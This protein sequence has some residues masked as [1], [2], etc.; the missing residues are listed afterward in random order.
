MFRFGAEA[1]AEKKRP[2]SYS[3]LSLWPINKQNAPK[4]RGREEGPRG[5]RQ[6]RAKPFYG[7][8]TLGK[9]KYFTAVYADKAVAPAC[10][11]CHNEHK[12]TPKKDFKLGDRHG[13]RGDP[14]PDEMRAEACTLRHP[15]TTETQT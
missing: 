14:H 2:F 10:V 11:T 13:R 4:T 7:E 8:E 3:L 5:G 15:S 1:V 12:D 9:V 6:G